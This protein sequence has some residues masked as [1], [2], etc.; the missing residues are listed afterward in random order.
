MNQKIG[1]A[2]IVIPYA[3]YVLHI[4]KEAGYVL[5]LKF[6]SIAVGIICYS[7]V[8]AYFLGGWK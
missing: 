7:V 5:G 8:T 6:W 3:L 1:L 4:F 2:M